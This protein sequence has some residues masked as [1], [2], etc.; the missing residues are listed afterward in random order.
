MPAMPAVLVAAALAVYAELLSRL[1]RV[2]GPTPPW[3]FGYARDAANLSALLM[4]W[5]AYL[6]VGFAAP[7]AFL[8]AGLSTL[9]AYLLDWLL[10]RALRW[11]PVRLLL[12]LPTLAWAALLALEPR[13]VAQLLAGLIAHVEPAP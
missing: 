11:R 2:D 1:R 12:A 5:G 13:A 4:L 8:A 7:V 9:T 3:W 6:L 10:A